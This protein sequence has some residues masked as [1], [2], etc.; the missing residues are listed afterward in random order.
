[1]QKVTRAVFYIRVSHKEQ[2]LHGLSLSAQKK[3]LQ[4]YAKAHN[5]KVVNTYVDEGVSGRKPIRLRPAL[6]EMLADAQE[7][8]FDL[9][10]FIKIDRYFRSVAEYHECQKI[11]DK[12]KVKWNAINEDYDITTASGRAFVNMKLTVAEMEADQTGERIRDV[13]DYKVK[14]GQ[15][16]T[17]AYPFG[18]KIEKRDGR[19]YLIH[20]PDTEHIVIDMIEHYLTYNSLRGVT[21]YINKKYNLNLL[22]DSVKRLLKNPYL[23]GQYRD[24]PNFCEPYISKETFDKM[25]EIR[26]KNIKVQRNHN[27]FLF[28]SLI[29]CDNCN[30][31]L[32]GFANRFNSN[33]VYNYYRCRNRFNQK[34]CNCPNVSERKLEKYL[35]E[36]IS[37]EFQNYFKK[38]ELE[39]MKNNQKNTK[40]EMAKIRAEMDRLNFMF[41]KNRI[42]SAVYNAEYEELESRLSDL[43]T[44]K[45]SKKR[46]LEP[47]KELLE[48]DFVSVYST[49]SQQNKQAFWRGIIKEI[50]Q[51]GEPDHYAIIFL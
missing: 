2:V 36:N 14:Q 40:T 51:L 42:T 6:Q 4:D 1:M 12:H 46:D 23:C 34:T 17:G 49:L 5:L 31:L 29:R 19:S 39:E 33:R 10:L 20:D 32:S 25:Q 24:N 30:A 41:Q 21:L 48:S 11:L 38:I 44:V 3:H 16:I 47:I 28:S 27:T 18:F 9:I 26:K 35:L 43:H 37:T 7:N 13:N 50:R 22:Q 45:T 8:Q 15:M